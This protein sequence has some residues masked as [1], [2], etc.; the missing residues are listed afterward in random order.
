MRRAKSQRSKGVD[1]RA[2]RLKAS[3]DSR[4]SSLCRFVVSI[5]GPRRVLPSPTSLFLHFSRS[6]WGRV[7]T[8]HLL[9]V[10]YLFRVFPPAFL[11]PPSFQLI[12]STTH[13]LPASPS[14]RA[15]LFI[16]HGPSRSHTNHVQFQGSSFLPN[17]ITKPVCLLLCQSYREF[18]TSIRKH[19]RRKIFRSIRTSGTGWSEKRKESGI[20][21]END[22][23][24][25]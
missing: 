10:F 7:Y 3:A 11:L 9:L 18:G 13:L 8:V 19:L 5:V 22:E 21:F 24:V 15:S 17:R 4:R 25:L 6:E 12:P 14:R 20:L 1:D 2:N 16:L 23:R